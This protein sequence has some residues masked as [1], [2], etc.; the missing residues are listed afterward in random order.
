[1]K[2]LGLIVAVVFL[3]C[4]QQSAMMDSE[5]AAK[6]SKKNN[7]VLPSWYGYP[8]Y[9]AAKFSGNTKVVHDVILPGNPSVDYESRPAQLANGDIVVLSDKGIHW[10]NK[11]KGHYRILSGLYFDASSP[12]VL[13]DGETVVA[14]TSQGKLVWAKN[15]EKLYEFNLFKEDYDEEVTTTIYP[16]VLSNDVV[17]AVA[18]YGGGFRGDTEI[19]WLKDGDKVH[20]PYILPNRSPG[21]AVRLGDDS[22]AIIVDK[23]VFWLKDG[24]KIAVSEIDSKTGSIPV[25]LED[26]ETIVFPTYSGKV[27][28]LK[29]GGALKYPT[30]DLGENLGVVN[31]ALLGGGEVVIGP[32][33]KGRVFWVKDGK[34]LAQFHDKE[35][36]KI[37]GGY[38]YSRLSPY[39]YKDGTTVIVHSCPGPGKARSFIWLKRGSRLSTLKSKPYEYFQA[40]PYILPSGEFVFFS[41]DYDRERE[42][43]LEVK[44][45]WIH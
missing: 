24:K 1:M 3:G 9:S 29:K 15:G 22:V 4:S 40:S 12:A 33:Y 28:W 30:L 25:V 7:A 6:N 43:E 19:F 21:G 38:P 32:G 10:L 41:R 18:N 42:P 14:A 5:L 13:S 23:Q 35:G 36:Q 44:A 34:V 37:C 20:S 2:F 11:Q 16:I 17:V 39:G 31:P 26:G 8:A 27:Y 45:N